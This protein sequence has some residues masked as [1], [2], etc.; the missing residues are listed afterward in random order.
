MFLS[1]R[2]LVLRFGAVAQPERIH[3]E[4]LGLSLAEQLRSFDGL[5]AR[6][7]PIAHFRFPPL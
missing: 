1:L 5:H 3:D 6:R 7:F 2:D 4:R